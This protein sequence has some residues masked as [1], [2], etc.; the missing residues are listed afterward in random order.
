[1]DPS[2]EIKNLYPNTCTKCPDAGLYP[3][4][5]RLFMKAKEGPSKSCR[6]QTCTMYGE[7]VEVKSVVKAE[8][9]VKAEEPPPLSHTKKPRLTKELKLGM[10]AIDRDI[11][12]AEESLAG[13]YAIREAVNG[14]PPS[15]VPRESLNT[16]VS[17]IETA[18]ETEADE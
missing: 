13:L 10:S 15:L 4:G 5:K 7:L 17:S 12:E 11:R 3:G 9:R 8:R 14:V 16:I 6:N 18:G 2:D 1:M